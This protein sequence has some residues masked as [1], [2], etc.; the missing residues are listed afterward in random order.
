MGLFGNSELDAGRNMYYRAVTAEPPGD[1]SPA[2]A[3]M[4]GASKTA[5]EY[6]DVFYKAEQVGK[7][8][9]QKNVL[10]AWK[11]KARTKSEATDI[12]YKANSIGATDIATWASEAMET[13]PSIAFG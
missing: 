13:L 4:L 8:E 10:E 12:Y 3:K 5:K 6:S 11:K 2:L 7:K 1:A 9:I